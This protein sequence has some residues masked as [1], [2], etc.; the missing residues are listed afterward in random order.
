[1]KYN[2]QAARFRGACYTSFTVEADTD[3]AANRALRR[4]LREDHGWDG[5]DMAG[6]H[7]KV[8]REDDPT[9]NRAMIL[10]E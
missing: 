2:V 5:H 3:L 9:F 4:V 7:M 1:M 6:A 10:G 8:H